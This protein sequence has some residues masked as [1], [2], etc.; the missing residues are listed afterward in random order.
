MVVPYPTETAPGLVR[1]LQ[2]FILGC[3]GLG[4]RGCSPGA[5]SRRRRPAPSALQDLG[6]NPRRVSR[7]RKKKLFAKRHFAVLLSPEQWTTDWRNL[8]VGPKAGLSTSVHG[9]PFSDCRAYTWE[10]GRPVSTNRLGI[11]ARSGPWARPAQAPLLALPPAPGN[12]R[13]HIDPGS[14]S[15]HNT[16][17]S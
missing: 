3:T 2:I 9:A 8:I 17:I 13:L 15:G 16:M 4:R 14:G 6:S 12:R 10:L 5:A 7:L 11:P 1:G